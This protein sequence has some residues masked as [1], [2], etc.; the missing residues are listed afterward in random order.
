MHPGSAV[1]GGSEYERAPNFVKC[2]GRNVRDRE[3][4]RRLN[5]TIQLC[6]CEFVVLR[7]RDGRNLVAFL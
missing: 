7:A 6:E 4:T 2:L 5:A 1:R 3:M